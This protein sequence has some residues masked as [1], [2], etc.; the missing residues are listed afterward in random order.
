LL[1][2][3]R[4]K[5]TDLAKATAKTTTVGVTVLPFS[6]LLNIA[7]Q[8]NQ[9]EGKVEKDSQMIKDQPKPTTKQQCRAPTLTRSLPVMDM[10]FDLGEG[11]LDSEEWVRMGPGMVPPIEPG[12]K[13]VILE[14]VILEN[15][16]GAEAAIPPASTHARRGSLSS[17]LKGA[18][19]VAGMITRP[20]KKDNKKAFNIGTIPS[21][22]NSTTM[23]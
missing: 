8:L 11:V 15:T 16:T 3:S 20:G 12:E 19:K 18:V 21:A 22:D 1:S 23:V 14:E 5:D 4:G 13:Q 9:E 17:M 10:D 6:E 2:E 7:S